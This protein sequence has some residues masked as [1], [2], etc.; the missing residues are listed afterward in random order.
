[1]SAEGFRQEM[2][3][4][5][6]FAGVQWQRIPLKKPWSGLKLF[7]VWAVVTAASYKVYFENIRLRR[8]LR[9]ENE[10]LTV[11]IEPLLI[12]ERDRM[13][14]DQL[15]KNREDEKELMKNVPDWEVG[16]LY[17][18]RVFKTVGDNIIDPCSV[19]Y[20]AHAQPYAR[21]Y[22]HTYDFWM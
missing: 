10:E 6:G 15:R 17:G 12:A 18:D 8:R 9:R 1:M 16:T 14:L 7:T 4:K 22:M 2:P 5:G 11:A 19:E 3:P 21:A 13:Y 20:Y